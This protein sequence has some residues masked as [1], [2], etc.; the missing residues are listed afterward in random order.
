EPHFDYYFFYSCF[1]FRPQRS[2]HG[3]ILRVNSFIKE[4]RKSAVAADLSKFFFF[5]SH[6]ILMAR[7]SRR[8]DDKRVLKLIGKYLRAGVVINNRL[9]ATPLGVPQGGPLSPL[10]ANIVCF[11]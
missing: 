1:G 10:L 3:A 2:A 4:W 5:F 9:Q 11:R 6:D 7:V 8:I